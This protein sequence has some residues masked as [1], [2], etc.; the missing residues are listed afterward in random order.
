MISTWKFIT[1]AQGIDMTAPLMPLRQPANPLD[2]PDLT[3][4]GID[5][6]WL[7]EVL[8]CW[9]ATHAQQWPL[10]ETMSIH[11]AAYDTNAIRAL[12]DDIKT[13]QASPGWAYQPIFD[14]AVRTTSFSATT[15]LA[16]IKVAF[17]TVPADV[18]AGDHVELSHV[19]DMFD[20]IKDV[21][22]VHFPDVFNVP[23]LSH[24]TNA[25]YTEGEQGI[26]NPMSPGPAT[27]YMWQWAYTHGPGRLNWYK[28]GGYRRQTA[29]DFSFSIRKE[30]VM[31]YWYKAAYMFMQVRSY[32]GSQTAYIPLGAATITQSGSDIVI[33]ATCSAA[34]AATAAK[35]ALGLTEVAYK[36]GYYGEGYNGSS[37]LRIDVTGSAVCFLEFADD[38]RHPSPQTSP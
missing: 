31:A 29:G 35:S 18:A 22:C 13:D 12:A 8:S 15:D 38:Y 20:W 33:S 19:S 14:S 10:L 32:W 17:G 24:T 27:L 1:P 2:P 11:P 5:T 21:V 6:A 9:R 3:R 4:Y 16:S 26:F 30:A 25:N 37:E 34:S 36:S 7:W 28:G 23:S